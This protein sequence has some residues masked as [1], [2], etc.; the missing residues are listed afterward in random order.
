MHLSCRTEKGEVFDKKKKKVSI[1]KFNYLV[2]SS[3]RNDN[4]YNMSFIKG[5]ENRCV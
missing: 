1:L 2:M 3:H 5:N 4:T